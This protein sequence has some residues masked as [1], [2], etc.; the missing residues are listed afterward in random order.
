M[1]QKLIIRFARALATLSRLV[2]RSTLRGS[3]IVPPAGPGSLGDEAMIE[4][5]AGVLASGGHEPINLVARAGGEPWPDLDHVTTRLHVPGGA[6]R[7][8]LWFIRQAM[9]HEYV[10]VVGADCVDGHYNTQNSVQLLLL[11]DLGARAGATSTLLGSSYKDGAHP[12]TAWMLQTMSARVRICA[13]DP[14]SGHRMD[15]SAR[16]EPR[17]VADAAFMLRPAPLT[18]ELEPITR[19]IDE[20]RGQGRVLLGVNFNRQVLPESREHDRDRLFDAYVSAL[21]E[22]GE[23]NPSLSILV[24]PHDYRGRVSDLSQGELL[25]DALRQ[26]LG[27]RV[28][29]VPGR[30][31]PGRLKAIAAR[32]DTVLTGR[33][34]FAIASLGNAIPVAGVSYQGKFE[35]LMDHFRIDDVLIDPDDALDPDTLGA[36]IRSVLDRRA[37]IREQ[38]QRVLPLVSRMPLENLPW[39]VRP[40]SQPAAEPVGA[41]LGRLTA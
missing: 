29:I 27:D 5:L 28:A 40:R 36:F 35:G 10:F 8:L 21:R 24:I 3:L 26:S 33:M 30:Q 37:E 38:I 13:R 32:M 1:K 25:C 23:Y 18:A 31:T 22:L 19:W 39:R 20:Q 4:G 16:C 7:R 34:H 12:A 14:R 41:R 11:A 6:V 15:E 2:P 9:R 17:L